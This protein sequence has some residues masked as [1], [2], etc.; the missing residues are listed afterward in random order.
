MFRL[1]RK[2]KP[3]QECP[4]INT[5]TFAF[6]QYGYI[7]AGQDMLVTIG[8]EAADYSK[9]SDDD[10]DSITSPDSQFYWVAKCRDLVIHDD[11]PGQA[12]RRMAK[13]NATYL[14]SQSIKVT[15]EQERKEM[16]RV[17]RLV[18]AYLQHV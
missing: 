10:L 3:C 16:N 18:A 17:Q 6:Q 8:M 4:Q 14:R 2:C 15:D 7:Y 9:L 12:V 13:A 1:F 11:N 5:F